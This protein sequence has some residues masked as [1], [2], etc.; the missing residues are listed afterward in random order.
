MF[1]KYCKIGT[2]NKLMHF[3][4]RITYVFDSGVDTSQAISTSPKAKKLRR[5]LSLASDS[6]QDELKTFVEYRF[7]CKY[8]R[9]LLKNGILY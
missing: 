1:L 6:S 3:F 8:I 5:M 2:Q 7:Y 9:P 4:G